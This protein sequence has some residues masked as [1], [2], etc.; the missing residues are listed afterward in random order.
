[1]KNILASK[2]QST[3]PYTNQEL[4]WLLENIGHPDSDIRDKLVYA[5]FCHILLNGLITR[6]QAQELLQR[7]LDTKP[8]S[9]EAS[10]LKRSFTC[11]LYCLLLS[12]DN[13]SESIYHAFFK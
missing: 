9:L 11:L 5:T 3:Q 7:S 13:D 12:V 1:M 4:A 2:L 10:T 8:F 6:E